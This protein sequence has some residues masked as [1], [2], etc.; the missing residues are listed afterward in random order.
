MN[1]DLLMPLAEKYIWWLSPEDAM[2]D[3]YR[4]IAQVMNL[5]A[6]KDWGRLYD[7]CS[8]DELKEAIA[9]AQ[10]GW[11]TPKRWRFWH[12]SL[13]LCELGEVP[14]LPKRTLPPIAKDMDMTFRPHFEMLSQAQRILWPH[15]GGLMALGFVLYGGTALALRI[16]HRHSDDFAFLTH[17]PLDE[18]RILEAAPVL[19]RQKTIRREENTWTLWAPVNEGGDGV[20][21]SFCGA[22][23]CGRVGTPELTEDAMVTVASLDDL[24]AH[25]LNNIYRR[26]DVNDYVDVADMIANGVDLYEGLGSAKT[27]FGNDFSQTPA[28]E[29]LL[30]F[31]GFGASIFP[32]R[33]RKTLVEATRK[34][35]HHPDE[36]LPQL[37]S[38]YLTRDEMTEKYMEMHV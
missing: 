35:K 15:L 34:E 11:F 7:A 30:W 17:L 31:E 6:W 2:T 16:G 28:L 4:V 8:D 27:L 3:P 1:I 24:M 26:A 32:E 22:N 10:A 19:Q 13:G 18:E 5:G 23:D 9:R 37:K 25:A 33:K 20:R 38:R 21:I 36:P 29:A 14:P 12:L